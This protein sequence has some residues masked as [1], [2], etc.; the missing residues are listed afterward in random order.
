MYTLLTEACTAAQQPRATKSFFFSKVNRMSLTQLPL[1][2]L[3]KNY[4]LPYAFL[5][6]PECLLFFLY[7]FIQL[8]PPF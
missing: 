3:H 4:E 5:D 6:F 8:A 2:L 7:M 1:R